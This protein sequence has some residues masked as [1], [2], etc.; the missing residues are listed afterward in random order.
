MMRFL[1]MSCR[2]SSAFSG[3]AYQEIEVFISFCPLNWGEP[4]GS[5]SSLET[6]EYTPIFSGPNGGCS[7]QKYTGRLDFY[8]KCQ[9]LS[10][11]IRFRGL[12]GSRKAVRRKDKVSLDMHFPCILSSISTFYSGSALLFLLWG[13]ALFVACNLKVLGSGLFCLGVPQISF[14]GILLLPCRWGQEVG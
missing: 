6:E 1:L 5:P 12:P 2:C 9:N 14:S 11:L 8:L 4:R 13:F 3:T 7:E 10:E